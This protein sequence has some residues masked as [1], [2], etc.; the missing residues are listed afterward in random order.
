[1]FSTAWW[2]PGNE[3]SLVIGLDTS[4]THCGECDLALKKYK[5][6][7]QSRR[8]GKKLIKTSSTST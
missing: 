8:K 5:P 4:P 7:S 3:K 2:T 6:R 1:M